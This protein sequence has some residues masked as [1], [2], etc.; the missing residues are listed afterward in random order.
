MND[1]IR[2]VLVIVDLCLYNLCCRKSFI[3]RFECKNI[4]FSE[5][6]SLKKSRGVY[7]IAI[8]FL[9]KPFSVEKRAMTIK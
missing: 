7:K 5:I 9:E 1:C 2:H 4:T 6:N 8:Y 3:T